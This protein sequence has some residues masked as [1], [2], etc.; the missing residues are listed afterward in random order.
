MSM[1]VYSNTESL[2]TAVTVSIAE[3]CK[4]S[5]NLQGSFHIALS[6]GNTPR[7]CYEMLSQLPLPWMNIHIYFSDER[8]LPVGHADR[9]DTMTGACLLSHVAIPSF[10]IHHMS[11][12]LAPEAGASAYADMLTNA[13]PMDLVL[14]GMGEDGHTASLFPENPALEDERL[15]VPVFNSPKPPSERISMGYSVLN[16]AG[17]R[18]VMAVGEG[19]KKALQRIQQGE[20]LP[21]ARL[22]ACEWYVDEAAAG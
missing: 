19:K 17:K 2:A 1:H 7:R 21:V 13:P 16:Q 9:N 10:H 6:G 11:S 22:A 14:L 3:C 15:A 8:C 4:N 20:D 12:E 18:I 5:I